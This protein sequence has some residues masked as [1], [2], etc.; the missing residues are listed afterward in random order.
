MKLVFGPG[1]KNNAPACSRNGVIPFQNTEHAFWLQ[2]N[3]KLLSRLIPDFWVFSLLFQGYNSIRPPFQKIL[4]LYFCRGCIFADEIQ[5]HM[6][7]PGS[8]I[9]K[10]LIFH[11]Q[12]R[13]ARLSVYFRWLFVVLAAVLVVVQY[14]SG[15]IETSRNAM[16]AVIIYFG[17]NII[18]HIA[19][20]RRYDPPFIRYASAGTDTTILCVH[21]Y[22]MAASSDQA[23]VVGAAT[24]FL[25]P[26]FFL[27]YTFRLDRGVLLFLIFISIAG[28]NIIYFD[29]YL[30]DP[31]YYDQSLSMSPLSHIFK[32]IYVFF[33]GG[34]CLFLQHSFF[35]FIEIQLVHANEKAELDNSIRMEQE[36]NRHAKEM[37]EKEK[38]LNMELEKE[39][40]HKEELTRR[41]NE[42]K[43][44]MKSIIS[45][46][47][48]FTYRCLPREG[49]KMIFISDQVETVCGYNPRCFMDN[50][51]ISYQSIIHPQDVERVKLKVDQALEKRI[52]FDLTYRLVHK[53]GHII[54]VHEAG[55]GVF[56]ARGKLL[57]IDGII[58]DI[59]AKRQ[60][61]N[62][63]KETQLLVATIIS[64]LSGA[65]SRCLYDQEFTVKYYSEKIKEITGYHAS[66][67]TD[68]FRVS[69]SQLIHEG[70]IQFVREQIDYSIRERQPYSLDF[71]ITHKNGQ[72]VWVNESGQPVFDKDGQLLYLDGITT[73][74]S[75]KKQAEEAL[76]AAKNELE[77]LNKKLKKLVKERTMALSEANTRLLELQKENLQSQLEVLKQQ[78]NPHFLFNSLNVLSSLIKVD[79]DLA[80]SF[81]EQLAKVYRYVLENK[82]KEMVTLKT[83]MDFLNAYLFLLNI[84]FEGKVYVKVTLKEENMVAMIVPLALQ[85]LIENAIKHNGF[86][87][88][89][90]LNISISDG[91]EP[92]LTVTNNRRH[93]NTHSVSTGVGLENIRKRYAM[94]GDAEP[95]FIKTDTHFL[96]KIPLLGRNA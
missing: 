83:E 40:Q 6:L 65:V 94:L 55:Q 5:N 7:K 14:S 86:S 16:I 19:V 32:S 8:K 15:H 80:E 17:I 43:K 20:K 39:I 54:W 22:N 50:N 35:R 58:T 76:K 60:A 84:R 85:L 79:E 41:L 10:D 4:L 75:E 77:G 48:G 89:T 57:Y 51:P 12:L 71:R 52:K 66:E 44:Q 53:E 13:G 74:I 2:K 49:W 46:L 36:E 11:E 47:V 25:I 45:N 61:D 28:M 9:S 33:I 96:A 1:L 63:L 92:F 27:I 42:S 29:R 95:E 21:I 90:P 64:N 91:D 68:N 82:E 72:L 62:A 70:D 18:F 78:V 73:D 23:A 34:L 67:L 30:A 81:T 24:L 37:I 38:A 93:R 56:D 87:R 88:K 59:T 3:K 31:S 69:F 26:V